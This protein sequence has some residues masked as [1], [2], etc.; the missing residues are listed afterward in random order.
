LQQKGTVA[1][2]KIRPPT[3]ELRVQ[4]TEELDVCEVELEHLG[5]TC[6]IASINTAFDFLLS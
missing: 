6:N 3:S 2:E 1:T 5:K 4:P